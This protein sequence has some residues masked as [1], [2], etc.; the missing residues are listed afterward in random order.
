M[1]ASAQHY[2]GSV[3]IAG[4]FSYRLSATYLVIHTTQVGEL[5]IQQCG[6]KTE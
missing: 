5:A 6:N 4:D 3:L 1:G 2:L